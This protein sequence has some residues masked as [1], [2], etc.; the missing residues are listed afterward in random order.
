[1]ANKLKKALFYSGWFI[2]FFAITIFALVVSIPQRIR[3]V[4]KNLW[5]I[6]ELPNEARD[7]GYWLFKFIVEK[8]PEIDV[9]YVLDETSP[10]YPK[11]PAKD[12]IIKPY[13]LKHYIAYILC[14][15][16][17]STHIYGACP[18]RY[19]GKIFTL[20]ARKKSEVFLQH[21]I[22]K[23]PIQLRG[24]SDTTIVSSTTE[25]PFLV[26]SGH[27]H[28]E[29][30][31][32]VGLCR[33]DS[34]MNEALSESQRILLI[35]PTF[36]SWLNDLAHTDV[37]GFLTSEFYREWQSVLSDE[38]LHEWLEQDSL[39]LIFYPHRQMQVFSHLFS[40]TSSHVQI[41]GQDD[42]DIQ[43]LLKRASLLVTDYSSVFY[44][45]S[46]MKKPVVFFPFD[47]SQFFSQHHNHSG[48]EYPFGDYVS[49][50]NQMIDVLKE[51]A[52]NDFRISDSAL[53]EV[54]NFFVFWDQ[55]NTERNFEA[56]SNL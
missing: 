26:Q 1:M 36:R 8:R 46:Y 21:G 45:F 6:M 56:I 32:L 27:K 29:R 4:H 49:S 44:D 55:D 30:I 54:E 41:A 34:L 53:K 17:I 2:K 16:S 38:T 33:F 35:M 3:K 43:D 19:F 42:Y 15:R 10:D 14:T 20:F 25:I 23:E 28:P 13:S 31:K 18:G 24:Y 7:N 11:M 5:L 22:L 50:K 12:R 52:K 40:S 47:S 51:Y 37:E 48:S 9:L 39:R